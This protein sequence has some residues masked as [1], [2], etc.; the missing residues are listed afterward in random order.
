MHSVGADPLIG[1]GPDGSFWLWKAFTDP[2]VALCLA[3]R[4]GNWS[5]RVKKLARIAETGLGS[6]IFQAIM[7]FFVGALSLPTALH[8]VLRA[9]AIG[10][11][12]AGCQRDDIKLMTDH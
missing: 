2:S 1:E 3:L 7:G 12:Q 9:V 11:A 5:E 4:A 8:A 10:V 6:Y